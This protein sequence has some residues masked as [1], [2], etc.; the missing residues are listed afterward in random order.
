MYLSDIPLSRQSSWELQRQRV[1]DLMKEGR[2]FKIGCLSLSLTHTHTL[3]L[4]LSLSP[5]LS[6]FLSLA[7]S[8][9]LALSVSLLA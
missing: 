1:V 8:L 3:S 4:T 7:R 6:L 2:D 5:S 9:C